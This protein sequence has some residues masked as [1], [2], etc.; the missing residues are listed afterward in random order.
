M[1][2]IC[3]NV[4][5]L[6]YL[7]VP[8]PYELFYLTLPC[9][10]HLPTSKLVAPPNVLHKLSSPSATGPSTVSSF[11]AASQK[12]T[13]VY[14]LAGA[15]PI[16]RRI[17]SYHIP[18]AAMNSVV[19]QHHQ[20]AQY[21]NLQPQPNPAL[22]NGSQ[23]HLNHHTL[24]S[25]TGIDLS[26]LE[27]ADPVFHPDLHR[28]QDASN[29]QTFRT[30]HPYDRTLEHHHIHQ[31]HG[32]PHTPQQHA[33]HYNVLTPTLGVHPQHSSIGRLQQEEEFYN[34]P[35]TNENKSNGHLS[36]RL[37]PNPPNLE[38]WRQRLFEVDEMITL[39]EDEYVTSVCGLKSVLTLLAS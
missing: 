22:H 23:P 21:R 39:S 36:T 27:D 30:P 18:V 4:P 12:P 33:I 3:S 37:V 6:K 8:G 31:Q 16:S 29:V 25:Q 9:R 2:A 32:S 24:A 7:R 26:G 20:L 15:P 19:H 13:T 5:R 10:N 11:K 35:D 1:R 14:R 28:L 17:A 38:E 34:T